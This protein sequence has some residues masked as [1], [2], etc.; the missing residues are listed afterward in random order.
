M[1]EETKKSSS[2]R[3]EKQDDQEQKKS[4]GIDAGGK[5]SIDRQI[6]KSERQRNFNQKRGES[7]AEDAHGG[8]PLEWGIAIKL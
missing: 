1:R 4:A 8:S 2:I 5:H 6:L 3:E 7:N